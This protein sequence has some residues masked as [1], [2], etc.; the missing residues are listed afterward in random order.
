MSRAVEDLYETPTQLWIPGV[1]GPKFN[2]TTGRVAAAV[3]EYDSDQVRIVLEYVFYIRKSNLIF[4]VFNQVF[5]FHHGEM[6]AFHERV[7]GWFT[8]IRETAPK[9]LRGGF[10]VR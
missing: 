1:A 3:V 10:F 6:R 4:F 7:T 2:I 5:S 9:E 8:R